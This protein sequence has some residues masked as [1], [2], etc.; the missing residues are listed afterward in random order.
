MAISRRW[1]HDIG[2]DVEAPSVAEGLLLR[3]LLSETQL[4]M[5]QIDTSLSY[6]ILYYTILSDTIR[7][8]TIRRAAM[9][10]DTILYY[11]MLDCLG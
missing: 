6:P 11:T 2:N 7:Y 10:C 4:P 9:R 3:Q 8:Y 5:A 1:D